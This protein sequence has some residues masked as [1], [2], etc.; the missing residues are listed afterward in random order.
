M[1]A[2]FAE[3]AL[4]ADGWHD[5]VRISLADGRIAADE[6]CV[7][8]NCASGLKYELPPQ[9]EKLDCTK[10]IDYAALR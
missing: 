6:S 5:K 2:I 9:N 7:L 1:T 10:P 8:F 3:Q 4:L